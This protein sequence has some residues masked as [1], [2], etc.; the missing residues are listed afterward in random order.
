MRA[1]ARWAWARALR[2]AL[3]GSLVAALLVVA[4]PTQAGVAGVQDVGVDANDMVY[5][6]INDVVYLAVDQTDPTYANR[7]AVLDPATGSVDLLVGLWTGPE[8]RAPPAPPEIDTPAF[9]ESA[10]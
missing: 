5:D 9:P 2:L 7:V 10:G 6:P 4:P 3:A 1:P 8:G